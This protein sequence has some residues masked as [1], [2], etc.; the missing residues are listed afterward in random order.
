[1]TDE[2]QALINAAVAFVY[3]DKAD[4]SAKWDAL[5]AAVEAK[6][7][8]EQPPAPF[9]ALTLGRLRKVVSYD[10]TTGVFVWR[11][12]AKTRN[13]VKA[14]DVAGY[15]SSKGYRK[16][17]ID[18]REQLAHRLAW[19]Y[20]HG[21]W[22]TNQIDH[23]NGDRADNRIV[24]LREATN[25]E[26]QQNRP[27]PSKANTSGYP[28]VSY[29]KDRGYWRA[30]ITVDGALI[31]LGQFATAEAAAAAY[32]AAKEIHHPF[33]LQG[34]SASADDLEIVGAEIV[35]KGW[36][37]TPV[38]P[39]TMCVPNEPVFPAPPI[40]I[41]LYQHKHGSL[42]YNYGAPGAWRKLIVTYR[43]ADE[44]APVT[45][46]RWG[47]IYDN[48]RGTIVSDVSEED[49]REHARGNKAWRVVRILATEVPT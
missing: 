32:Q 46:E 49:A 36:T 45:H 24:N 15:Y 39:D 5:A 41:V 6:R 4:D 18:G 30:R 3:T 7:V 9:V 22:P 29:R 44:P 28:G 11:S 43:P 14:G 26:N 31:N 25:T 19:L 47:V 40:D 34:A 33:G 35:D 16:I 12:T 38:D 27:K 23:I 42:S 21:V 48:G 13:G 17:T 37:G 20:V 1:M 8:S 2:E 10:P